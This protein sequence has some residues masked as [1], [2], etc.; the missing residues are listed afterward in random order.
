MGLNASSV[1]KIM[2]TIFCGD[3]L[4]ISVN[5]DQEKKEKLREIE[6][7]FQQKTKKISK[8]LNISTKSSFD[9]EDNRHCDG[10][11]DITLKISCNQQNYY[12]NEFVKLY[13]KGNKLY[14]TNWYDE[15]PFSNIEQLMSFVEKIAAKQ[16]ESKDNALKS[17]KV[18][19]LKEQMIIS[20][21]KLLAKELG[22]FYQLQKHYRNKIKLLVKLD[23]Q[24]VMSVDIP[25]G[26]FQKILKELRTCIESVLSLYQK[27]IRF[28]IKSKLKYYNDW[29]E[30]DS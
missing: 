29:I 12:D 18:K 13:F 23:N 28:G 16:K 8:S 6:K 14:V 22:F 3:P 11:E 20:R 10:K 9:S 4:V 30:P 21:V 7:E 17:Q 27:G 5:T 2:K 24:Y 1:K 15:Y 25:H 19:D 26:R